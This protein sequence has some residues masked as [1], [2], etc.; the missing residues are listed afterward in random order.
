MYKLFLR[1]ILILTTI[2]SCMYLISMVIAD[3]YFCFPFWKMFPGY[4]LR[5]NCNLSYTIFYT[6][7]LICS[8]KF[9]P[10]IFVICLLLPA[11]SNDKM[12]TEQTQTFQ[13]EQ[14]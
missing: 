3:F 9:Q 4:V 1:I 12:I 6:R 2:F 11:A 10:Q 13:T 5:T 14:S 7:N 8:K